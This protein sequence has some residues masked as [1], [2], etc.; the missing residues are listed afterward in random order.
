M[1][2]RIDFPDG[3][4]GYDWMIVESKGWLGN[5]DVI[6]DGKL[7]VIDF[8][9]QVRLSQTIADEVRAVGYSTCRNIVVVE[10]ATR[11]NID[12]AVAAIARRNGFSDFVCE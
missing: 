1:N 6:C 11:E 2:Y 5:T 10:R 9:D 12:S 4:D 8:Y 3:D 7:Y